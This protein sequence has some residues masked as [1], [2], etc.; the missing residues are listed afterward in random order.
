VSRFKVP[1]VEALLAQ[2][3]SAGSLVLDVACGTGFATRTAAAVAG[4]GARIEG[5]DL[6]PSVL[7]Q[8]RAV[9]DDSGAEIRWR[10]ASL[11]LPYEDCRFDAVICHHDLQFFSDP[12]AGIKEIA[13]HGAG[14]C[15]RILSVTAMVGELLPAFSGAA[16][17]CTG[18]TRRSSRRVV[19]HRHGKGC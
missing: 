8:A 10:Q 12:G 15:P 5:L 9:S 7:D 2:T 1:F 3:V 19:R 4:T 18:R 16:G 6:N 11:A 14:L 17:G 13:C